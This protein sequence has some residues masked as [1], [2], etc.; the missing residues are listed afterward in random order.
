MEHKH[1]PAPWHHIEY[2]G[3]SQLHDGDHYGATNLL[4]EDECSAAHFNGKLAA[5]APE[6]LD[7]L[8]ILLNDFEHIV[9]N[10]KGQPAYT[11]AKEAIKKATE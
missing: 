8:E 7:A 1:T 5:A 9:K 4:D 10:A 11:L 3:Y 6:L 2:S